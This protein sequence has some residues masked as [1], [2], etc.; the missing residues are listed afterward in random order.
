MIRRALGAVYVFAALIAMAG[1]VWLIY[2]AISRPIG[3]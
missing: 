1:W 3:G 2:A